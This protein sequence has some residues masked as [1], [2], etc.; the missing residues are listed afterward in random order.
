VSDELPVSAQT[1]ERREPIEVAPLQDQ[2]SGTLFLAV[3]PWGEVYVDGK[4]IGITPP[5]KSY[6]LPAGR[7]LVTVTN[8]SLPIYQR[9]MT[10][11]P[12]TKIRVVHDFTCVSIRDSICREG[13]NKGLQLRSRFTAEATEPQPSR[14]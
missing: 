2:R 6:E 9:E 8:S 13:V 12:D 11:E 1:R 10:V 3:K 14:E 5:L 7:H 4:R